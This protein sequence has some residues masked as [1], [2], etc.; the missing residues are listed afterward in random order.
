MKMHSEQPCSPQKYKKGRK[1][2]RNC[3]RQ[4]TKSHTRFSIVTARKKNISD[5]MTKTV[6]DETV[7]TGLFVESLS[8]KK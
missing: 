8:D 5:I 7:K 3:Q 1:R 2:H 6:Y 4:Y